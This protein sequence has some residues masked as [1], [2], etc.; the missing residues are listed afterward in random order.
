MSTVTDVRGVF[1]CDD[2]RKREM[3]ERLG[4][5]T[6]M[7]LGYHWLGSRAET[8]NKVER[9]NRVLAA[10]VQA[11]KAVKKITTMMNVM[12]MARMKKI[13][14]VGKMMMVSELVGFL[15]DYWI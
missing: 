14:Y 2:G 8:A 15:F 11:G 13:R 7:P 4:C 1:Y 9:Y 5:S 10:A 3:R 6:Q 12:K